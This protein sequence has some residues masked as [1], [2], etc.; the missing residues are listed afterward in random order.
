MGKVIIYDGDCS[1]CD[2]DVSFIRRHNRR[3][4]FEFIPLQ[5]DKGQSVISR[6]MVPEKD[7]NTVLFLTE[8]RYFIRSAAI[9]HILR[10]MGGPWRYLYGF[11]IVP[12]FIR[13]AVYRFVARHR[14]SFFN[15]GE[16]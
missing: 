11:I 6:L 2:N 10:E 1:L 9:L 16:H 5:S 8:K 7:R 14:K 15:H 3:G 12:S 13:D 4:V